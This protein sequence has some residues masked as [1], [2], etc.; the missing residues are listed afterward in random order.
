MDTSAPGQCFC[1]YENCSVDGFSVLQTTLAILARSS[2]R[3]TVEKTRSSDLSLCCTH[4]GTAL[5]L[6]D[7][8][9]DPRSSGVALEFQGNLHF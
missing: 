8:Y 9:R 2:R 6:R 7:I 1:N 4:W 3:R 5:E